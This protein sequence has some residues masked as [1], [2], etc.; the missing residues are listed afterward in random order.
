L[1]STLR[2]DAGVGRD[3]RDHDDHDDDPSGW[4]LHAGHDADQ[5]PRGRLGALRRR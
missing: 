3:A 5:P 2:D 4:R 1:S